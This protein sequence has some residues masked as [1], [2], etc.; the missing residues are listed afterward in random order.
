MKLF[1]KAKA[2]TKGLKADPGC[3]FA[4]EA[5]LNSLFLKLKPPELAFTLPVKGSITTIAPFAKGNCLSL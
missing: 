4:C 5:L 1:S 2:Y 3:L